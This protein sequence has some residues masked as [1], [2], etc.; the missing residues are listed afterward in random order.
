MKVLSLCAEE[1]N[2]AMFLKMREMVLRQS[3]MS[4]IEQDDQVR[5]L[6]RAICKGD[7]ETVARLC[8]RNLSLVS[9]EKFE[10]LFFLI[11]CYLSDILLLWTKRKERN[12]WV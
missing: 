8:G 12:M 3:S 2:K 9:S 6:F 1:K 11:H 4:F 10:K 7:S 5:D